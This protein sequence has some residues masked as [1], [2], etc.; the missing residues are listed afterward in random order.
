MRKFISI[1]TGIFLCLNSFSQDSHKIDSLKR[2]LLASSD[3]TLKGHVI[4]GLCQEFIY[5]KPDS[6]LYYAAMGF[7]L[8]KNPI[9]KK[10]FES[11]NNFYLQNFEVG[12]YTTSAI[13]L[14]EQRSDSLAINN[15]IKST[16]VSRK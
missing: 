6:C 15:G 5:T 10:Q 16:G 8:I 7:D 9:I 14:S 12:L 3:D 11:S 4:W 2:I 13:A 1:F